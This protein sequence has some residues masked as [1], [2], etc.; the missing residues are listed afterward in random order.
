MDTIQVQPNNKKKASSGRLES[1][2]RACKNKGINDEIN[3]SLAEAMKLFFDSQA[4]SFYCPL[5]LPPP[6]RHLNGIL[7]TQRPGTRDVV[8][9]SRQ[10]APP[11]DDH[12]INLSIGLCLEIHPECLHW[13][14]DKHRSHCLLRLNR[15]R[16]RSRFAL[17]Q[18]FFGFFLQN[19]VL[20][21]FMTNLIVGDV[22]ETATIKSDHFFYWLYLWRF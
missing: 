15:P 18:F 20:L 17:R 16:S 1:R 3:S 4:K 2:P 14:F 12:S 21:K 7:I 10:A 19:S 9:I 13:A 22:D 5:K 11:H 6:A 8:F